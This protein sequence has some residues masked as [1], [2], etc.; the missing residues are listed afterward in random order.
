MESTAV[1]VTGMIDEDERRAPSPLERVQRT[2]HKY[3]ALGPLIVLILL[4]ATFSLIAPERFLKPF[5]LSLIISQVTVVGTLAIG[6]TII[7]LTAGVDLSVGAIA[8]FASIVM[9]NVNVAWGVPGVLALILGFA[10]G[11]GCGLLNGWL[12]TRFRMPPFIVTLG[13]L[14][15]FFALDLYVSGS[16]TV[17]GTDMD[18]ILVLPGQ[19]IEFLGTRFTLGSI[20]MLVAYGIMMYLLRFTAWGRHIFAVGD[21]PESARLSGVRTDRLLL[22]VYGAAGLLYALGAWFLLG[23]INAASPQALESANLETITAVVIGGTSLFGGRGG[24]LGTLFGAIIVG[25]AVNG[26]TIAG[27]DPLWQRFAIGVLVIVA[28][29]MDQWIRRVGK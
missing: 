5:N 28:V 27:F 29:G 7:I 24:V 22:S 6:Q 8:V 10:F 13:T 17:R 4:I 3:P 14:S 23:R 12:I 18:P 15:I 16:A 2:L 9:A 21:E 20:G 1:A 25:T 26:L 19:V 11:T